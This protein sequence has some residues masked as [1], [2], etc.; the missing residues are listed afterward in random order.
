MKREKKTFQIK[1]YTIWI[2]SV[3]YLTGACVYVFMFH[4]FEESQLSVS[5][6]GKKFGLEGP[7]KFLDGHLHVWSAV[8]RWAETNRFI[9]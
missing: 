9:I 3:I 2:T 6:F 5:P 8:P 1:I 7:V 4:V